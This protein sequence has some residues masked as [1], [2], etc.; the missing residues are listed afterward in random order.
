MASASFSVRLVSVFAVSG[1]SLSIVACGINVKER[2]NGKG[3]KD[4]TIQSPVANMH[5]GKDVKGSDTG[6][7]VYPGAK[8]VE[9]DDDNGSDRANVNISTPFFGLKLV[10]VK[11]VSDDAPQ[12]L[13]DFYTNDLKRYGT[14]LHCNKSGSDADWHI[15][16]DSHDN[17]SHDKSS[18]GDQLS[19]SGDG[20]GD[21]VELKVGSNNNAHVV[22]ITPKGKGAEFAL[23]YVHARSDN[24]STI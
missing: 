14:I 15:G 8:L 4:V 16:Y 6:I 7:A 11:Y 19:C 17:G 12:K 18:R 5:V 20:K 21:T 2:D 22:A 10:V 3:D 23:V 24:D 1:L 13:V 9:K